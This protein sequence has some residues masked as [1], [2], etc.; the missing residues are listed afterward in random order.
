MTTKRERERG[1]YIRGGGERSK[2]PRKRD[3]EK[4]EKEKKK[5]IEW[6]SYLYI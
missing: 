3:K 5:S 6:S 2:V 1:Y 4:K